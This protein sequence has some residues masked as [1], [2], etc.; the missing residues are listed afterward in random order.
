MW[1]CG[2]FLFLS[3]WSYSFSYPNITHI[4]VQYEV[5]QEHTCIN[6]PKIGG[7]Q[8]HQEEFVSHLHVLVEPLIAHETDLV[9]GQEQ[10][11][12]IARPH[13]QNNTLHLKEVVGIT[14]AACGGWNQN[15]PLHQVSHHRWHGLSRYLSGQQTS[16][17]VFC[18]IQRCP[19]VL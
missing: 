19:L 3:F 15:W 1:V 4:Q 16:C 2:L 18:A 12:E 7:G 8:V 5:K 13:T 6:L 17:P 10:R 11:P 9:E 14:R